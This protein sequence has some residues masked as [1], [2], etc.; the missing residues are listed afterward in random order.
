[1]PKVTELTYRSTERLGNF[2]KI[3]ELTYVSREWS[4]KLPKTTQLRRGSRE[5]SDNLFKVTELRSRSKERS[6]KLPKI[7][8]LFGGAPR[9]QATCLSFHSS[10]SHLADQ[11]RAHKWKHREVMKF[12]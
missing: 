4:C 10:V 11:D 3:T 2:P 9:G 5:R 1:M 12:S 7:P 6:G 8:W